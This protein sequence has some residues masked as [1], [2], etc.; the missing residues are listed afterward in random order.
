MGDRN[1]GFT[2]KDLKEMKR[3]QC[4]Q[5]FLDSGFRQHTKMVT[6]KTKV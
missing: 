2:M 5:M 6:I 4:F 3:V 1:M